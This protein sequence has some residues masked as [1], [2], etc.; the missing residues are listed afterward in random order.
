MGEGLQPLGREPLSQHHQV[1]A[2]P[3]VLGEQAVGVREEPLHGLYAE[4]TGVL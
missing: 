1:C 4:A 2:Y 3:G